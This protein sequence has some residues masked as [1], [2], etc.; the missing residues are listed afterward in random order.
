MS[1]EHF[2]KVKGQIGRCGIWCGSCVVGNGVLAELTRRYER[3]MDIYDLR[4]WGPKDFNYDEFAQGLHS[5]QKMVPCPGCLK[6]GGR[7][8]CELRSCAAARELSDCSEC[9]DHRS[10]PHAAL[11]ETMRSGAIQ[12]GLFVR[13]FGEGRAEAL[14]RWIDELHLRWPQTVLFDKQNDQWK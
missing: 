13:D 1:T 2:D 4:D 10:C 12:A 3:L 14:S 6:G 8:A 7:D 11:L 5:I 9:G